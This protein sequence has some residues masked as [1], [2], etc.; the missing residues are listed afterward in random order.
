VLK[1]PITRIF[2]KLIRLAPNLENIL[3][4]YPKRTILSLDCNNLVS[5]QLKD[6]VYDRFKARKNFAVRKHHISFFDISVGKF[7][8]DADVYGP[9]LPIVRKIVLDSILKIHDTFGI[10]P[11]GS[12]RASRQ[13]HFADFCTKSDAEISIQSSGTIKNISTTQVKKDSPT[14][15][16]LQIQA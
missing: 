2:Y 10:D 8:F 4:T 12:P 1:G 15:R 3:R 13:L 6:P 5:Y 11:A 16:G 7:C 9:F 14:R